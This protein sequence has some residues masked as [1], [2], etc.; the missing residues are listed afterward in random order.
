[1][2]KKI[3]ENIGKT[4]ASVIVLFSLIGGVW[5]FDD[6]YISKTEVDT[7]MKHQEKIVIATLQKFKQQVDYRWYQNLYDQLT[8]QILEYRNLLRKNPGDEILKQEYKE[9][10]EE[11]KK[12]KKILDD[13]LSD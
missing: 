8:V 9:I 12:I 6:R 11:R 10:V 13:L 3:K 5:A 7:K 4:I 2:I 1:M